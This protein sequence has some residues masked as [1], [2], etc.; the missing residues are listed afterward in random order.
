MSL[1]PKQ[2]KAFTMIELI[3]VIV[4]MG[5][6][7]KF[8]VEFLAQAYKSFIFS[9][10]NNELQANS[11]Y[12]T[13]LISKRLE[14]RIKQ[15]VIYRSP[16]TLGNN[17]DT[18]FRTLDSG[19]DANA[20]VLEWIGTDI[21]GY[22]DERW[23]GVIDLNTTETNATQITSLETNTTSIDNLI[24]ILSNN[25][26]TINDAAIYFVGTYT[27]NNQW[28]WDGNVTE[29]NTL[30][31]VEIYPIN[32]T[33]SINKF[34][35]PAAS[36]GGY[37]GVSATEYY[38]LAWTAYA[39]S[40]ESNSTTGNN[41]LYLYHNYQPWKGEQYDDTGIGVEKNLIM[42]NVSSFQFRAAG[43]L[44]KIQICTKNDLITNEEYSI[45]KEKT[46]Y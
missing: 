37:T 38:K 16:E 29:F 20:T 42:H 2:H 21:E 18:N 7:A 22:I 8:G 17:S 36:V 3:F 9:K 14:H 26:S 11:A 13:E 41:D 19:S 43:S 27:G 6:L 15:S 32:S 33:T 24:K 4:I 31:N 39:V 5:I 40:L 23:S 30:S 1:N 25:N 28:G 34:V 10:V 35:P 45:C 46:V 44:I 12:A